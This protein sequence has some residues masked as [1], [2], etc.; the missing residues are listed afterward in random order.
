MSIIFSVELLFRIA[1][2]T[3]KERSLSRGMDECFRD[4]IRYIDLLC[5]ILELVDLL[6]LISSRNSHADGRGFRGAWLRL[7]KVF[8]FFKFLK[9]LS[10]AP[11]A[12][13]AVGGRAEK[14]YGGYLVL[15]AAFGVVDV[16]EK[17]SSERMRASYLHEK[18]TAFRD[19]AQ[20][21]AR[22]ER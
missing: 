2:H 13:A 16:I 22:S 12:T 9:A 3:A 11:D 10:G 1:A 19:L 6:S 20:S 15:Q 7:V 18:R 5:I 14:L 17:R 8:R 21:L 4:P